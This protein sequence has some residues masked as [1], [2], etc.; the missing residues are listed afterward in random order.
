MSMRRGAG[1]LR[2]HSRGG[3]RLSHGYWGAGDGVVTA[4]WRGVL[5]L[6]CAAAVE[7]NA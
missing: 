1:E 5:A 4:H 2:G 6:R 7:G 3:A